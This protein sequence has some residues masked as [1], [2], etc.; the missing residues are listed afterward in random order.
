MKLIGKQIILREFKKSDAEDLQKNIN[1]KNVVRFTTNIPHPY[2][3]KDAYKFFR[4]LKRNREVETI[5][6]ILLKNSE[7][8]VGGIGLHKIDRKNKNA[9]LE[10]WLGKKYWGHGIATEAVGL[11]LD[12]VFKKWKF[13]R[14]YANTFH[15]NI[16]SQ[17]VLKKIGFKLEDRMR[18]KWW[19]GNQWHDILN[20]GIL[21]REYKK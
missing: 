9:E 13:H 11:V 21:K 17:K 14:I 7:E 18:E 12:L 8:I 6:G 19:R 3:I 4:K 10:Y 2:S 20:F 1:D 5:F 16:A 15:K